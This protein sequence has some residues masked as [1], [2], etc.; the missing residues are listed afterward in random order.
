MVKSTFYRFREQWKSL[1]YFLFSKLKKQQINMFCTNKLQKLA[2]KTNAGV[3][4][5]VSGRREL[6]DGWWG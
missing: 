2:L 1:R 5:K 3:D 6:V 4:G